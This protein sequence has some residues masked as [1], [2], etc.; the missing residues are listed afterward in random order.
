[1]Q[2][3]TILWTL[4]RDSLELSIQSAHAPEQRAQLKRGEGQFRE[5]ESDGQEDEAPATG[6][7]KRKSSSSSSSTR[8]RTSPGDV[9]AAHRTQTQM[10]LGCDGAHSHGAHSPRW[11]VALHRV[12]RPP[13]RDLHLVAA[14]IIV[15]QSSYRASQAAP[16]SL[17]SP[18]QLGGWRTL[19]R[20]RRL[21]ER[22]EAGLGGGA[23]TLN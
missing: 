23:D 7:R 12:P 18:S 22:R 8:T 16:G 17:L 11:C 3:Y 13:S 19:S 10:R 4:C 5:G 2:H 6:K 1:M 9:P 15:L 20:S 14:A 21:F